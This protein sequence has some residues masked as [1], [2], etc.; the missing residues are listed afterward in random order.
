MKNL[1]EDFNENSRTF[2]IQQSGMGVYMK[3][4]RKMGLE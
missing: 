1:I 3:I 2:S 4:V